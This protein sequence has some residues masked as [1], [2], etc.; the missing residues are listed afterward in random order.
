MQTTM[1]WAAYDMVVLYV[2]SNCD[3]CFK[4][5]AWLEL[6][7]IPFVIKNIDTDSWALH[8]FKAYGV[9]GTPLLIDGNH[10]IV[11]FFEGSYSILLKN[12][13]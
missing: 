10:K 9:K 1:T 5:K 4:A 7:Q 13:K 8:E 6:H 2:S 3:Y 11:G 12:N